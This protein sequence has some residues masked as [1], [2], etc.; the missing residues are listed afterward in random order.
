M[1]RYACTPSARG[2]CA[3]SLLLLVLNAAC[4]IEHPAY[5]EVPGAGGSDQQMGAGTLQGG[6]GQPA[7]E[8]APPEMLPV[9]AEP[10]TTGLPP[11]L[12]AEPPA[13][14]G[15][16]MPLRQGSVTTSLL[17][18]SAGQVL[19]GDTVTF[20][21]L[22]N[23]PAGQPLGRGGDVVTFTVSGGDA[24]GTFGLVQDQGNGTYSAVFT[25]TRAGSAL[26]VGA[27]LA[28][29]AI[30]SAGPSLRVL[31]Y[32]NRA[33]SFDGSSQFLSLGDLLMATGSFSLWLNTAATDGYLVSKI[34]SGGSVAG[35][36]RLLLEAGRV[37]FRIESAEIAEARS[38][39]LLND[40]RWH[41]VLVTFNPGLA[42]Y[43]DGQL[44]G[45]PNTS[46]TSGL[47]VS[48]AT[49][50]IGRNNALGDGHYSGLL[51]ELAFYNRPLTASEALAIY[52][53]GSP[54][55]LLSLGTGGNLLDW[56]HLGEFDTPPTL[57]DSVGQRPLTMVDMSATNL[58]TVE[59]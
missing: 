44:Q 34:V 1:L 57:L 58:V 32:S 59:R 36:L 54:G 28:G 45:T 20:Q 27:T 7:E 33:I 19:E 41:N 12:P 42:L 30:T 18:V 37:V 9:P 56:W 17:S 10:P 29:A 50:E 22:V 35:E 26:S 25:A 4:S 31:R 47:L 52:G 46:N 39:V 40:S 6:A 3:R 43:V 24:A 51:D 11:A 55:D 21:L 5:F 2:A 53:S 8:G 13:P 49:L 15:V 38:D 48:G 23:D 16:M 14:P